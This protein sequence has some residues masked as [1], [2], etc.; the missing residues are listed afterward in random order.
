MVYFK[1]LLAG[2]TALIIATVLSP[3]IMGI[4]LYVVY[5]P[6]ANEAIGW[7]P[8]SFA[9]RPLIWLVAA[10]TFLTGFM[11]ELAAPLQNSPLP[12][13]PLNRSAGRT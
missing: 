6:A 9:K 10:L 1:S 3:L 2:L 5:R 7:D 11:W 12:R 8:I 4:Y 13:L